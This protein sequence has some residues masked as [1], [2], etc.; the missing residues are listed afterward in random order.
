MEKTHRAMKAVAAKPS[1]HLL[2]SMR[3]HDDAEHNAHDGENRILRGI[4][5]SFQHTIPAAAQSCS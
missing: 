2:R 5:K 3:E 4:E 1:E